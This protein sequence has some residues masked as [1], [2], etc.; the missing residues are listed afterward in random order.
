M[1]EKYRNGDRYFDKLSWV[2]FEAPEGGALVAVYEASDFPAVYPQRVQW[3]H[4]S[5]ELGRPIVVHV[6]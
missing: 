1:K 5:Q 4:S 2:T 6:Q 3:L